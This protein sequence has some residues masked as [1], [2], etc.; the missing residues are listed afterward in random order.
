MHLVASCQVRRTFSNNRLKGDEGRPPGIFLGL[1]NQLCNAL[2]IVCITGKH[3][4]VVCCKSC[5]DILGECQL[6]GTFD[7]DSVVVVE[8]NQLAQSQVSCK[9]CC[10]GSKA[11][12]HT[13]VA[14]KNI[15]VVVN[16]LM[17]LCIEFFCQHSL[18]NCHTYCICETCTQ[19]TCGSFDSVC[20]TILRVSWSL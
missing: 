14:G 3:L 5:L 8:Y 18:G 19:R 4:P 16:D 11:F 6:G 10:L 12:H 1:G 17:L 13:A 15:G 7:C 20:H 2:D 9:G